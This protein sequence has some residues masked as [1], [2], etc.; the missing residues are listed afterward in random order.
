MVIVHF[1]ALQTSRAFFG[2]GDCGLFHVCFVTTWRYSGPYFTSNSLT[3]VTDFHFESISASVWPELSSS[4]YQI[5]RPIKEAMVEKIFR[6]QENNAWVAAHWTKG[7]LFI[8]R[9][10]HRKRWKNWIERNGDYV[11]NIKNTGST[12]TSPY[13]SLVFCLRNIMK[14]YDNFGL[15]KRTYYGFH[16]PH[17][18][19]L[20]F[21]DLM[22]PS[23]VAE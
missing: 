13:E 22:D 8:C 18:R 4:G 14:F 20:Y 3:V 17:P 12:I 10:P 6:S 11:S 1:V 15:W 9:N 21:S 5:F 16:L 2:S 7:F 19:N 23:S